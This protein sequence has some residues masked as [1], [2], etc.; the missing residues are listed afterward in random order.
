MRRAQE[1]RGKLDGLSQQMIQHIDTVT[2]KKKLQSNIFDKSDLK[3]EAHN[4]MKNENFDE[5]RALDK[6]K[7]MFNLL[8]VPDSPVKR[9]YGY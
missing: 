7:Q 5:D 4:L 8:Y 9:W 1:L 2:T 3:Q 6:F